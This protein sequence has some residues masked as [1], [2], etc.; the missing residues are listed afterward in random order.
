MLFTWP[1]YRVHQLGLEFVLA[2]TAAV[3]RNHRIIAL[4]RA[5][6][7]DIS[8]SS[9]STPRARAELGA[10]GREAEPLQQAKGAEIALLRHRE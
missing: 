6:F 7:E 2:Q 4:V 5:T 9:G 1:D 10:A 8:V 3:R